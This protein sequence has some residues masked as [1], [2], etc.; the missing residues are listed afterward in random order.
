M[1]LQDLNKQKLID[2]DYYTPKDLEKIWRHLR[3]YKKEHSTEFPKKDLLLKTATKEN[4]D[5]VLSI[6]ADTWRIT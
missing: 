4:P 6:G 2:L 3:E 5:S 1:A